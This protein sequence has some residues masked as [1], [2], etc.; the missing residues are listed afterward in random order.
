MRVLVAGWFSFDQMGATAGDLMVR[1]VVCRWI[2]RAGLECDVAHATPFAGGVDWRL[3]DPSEYSHVIFACGPFGNGPPVVEFLDRFRGQKLIGVSLSMLQDLHEW[4]PFDMLIARDSSAGAHADVAFACRQPRVPVVGI[5]LIH[6]QPE[7]G[8][9]DVHLRANATIRRLVASRELAAVPIDTRLDINVTGL[10]TAAEVESLIAGMDVVVTTRLHGMV[11]ALKNG[12]PVVVVD[13]VAG[14]AKIRR[15][16]ET[17]AWPV[18]LDGETVTD[19]DLTRAFDYCLTSPAKEAAGRCARRAISSL[20]AVAD[21]FVSFL[22][23][24]CIATL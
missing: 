23:H 2:R 21:D 3:V 5:V 20:Q 1:D 11:L 10:R 15:Q 4:N 16:A 24:D 9:R 13:P 17:I 19:G 12:V 18:V 6:P 8:S 7:Y 14:G 22:T